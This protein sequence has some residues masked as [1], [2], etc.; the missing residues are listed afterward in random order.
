MNRRDFLAGL[1]SAGSMSALGERTRWAEAEP[2]SETKVLRLVRAPALCFA[3]TYVAEELLASE[4]FTGVR[5]VDTGGGEGTRAALASGDVDFAVVTAPN[6]VRYAD[7]GVPAILLSGLHVGCY[8]LVATRRI[9]AIR[10]LKGKTIAVPSLGSGPDSFLVAMLV[11]VGLNPRTD[12]E[13]VAHPSADAIRLLGEEKIDAYM[14][15]PPEPQEMRMRNIGHAL[16][17]T[18][19]DRPWSQYFCCTIV[20]NREFVRKNP[21][22]TKRALRAI[23]KATQ[24]C[25]AEPARVARLLVDKGYTRQYEYAVQMFKELPYARWREFEPEDAVRFFALR[26]HEAGLVKAGPK[27]IIAGHTD[28]RFLNELKKE[29][30]G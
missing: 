17:N 18:T 20:G 5:Y 3:P 21:V 27:K 7:A 24:L 13:F 15:F 4:G 19:L 11:H 6:F 29:L 30:K 10:D 25:A 1:A 14:A 9:R 22:A 26:L 2:V 16:I 23:L 12:V 8:E 28:W